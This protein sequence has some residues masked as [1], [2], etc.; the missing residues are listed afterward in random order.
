MESNRNHKR[1]SSKAERKFEK[2]M[3][4]PKVAAVEKV[5]VVE[6]VPLHMMDTNIKQS[7]VEEIAKPKFSTLELE[8]IE[9]NNTMWKNYYNDKRMRD[10]TRWAEQHD[11]VLWTMYNEY[12]D[13]TLHVSFSNFKKLAYNCTLKPTNYKIK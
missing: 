7:Y 8:F 11:D 6:K 12:M 9:K 4:K 1:H 2:E 13:E 3:K 10:F 5:I